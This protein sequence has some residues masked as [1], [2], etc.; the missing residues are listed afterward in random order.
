MNQLIVVLTFI[1]LWLMGCSNYRQ[2]VLEPSDILQDEGILMESPELEPS[3]TNSNERSEEGIFILTMDK[4]L[5]YLDPSLSQYK[6][7]DQVAY[8]DYDVQTHSI[9][10]QK[11]DGRWVVWFLDKMKPELVPNAA[12][13]K[14]LGKAREIVYS[15]V[16]NEGLY[17]LKEGESSQLFT[18]AVKL[19]DTTL[20]GQLIIVQ[21]QDD[22]LRVIDDNG[23]VVY[24]REAVVAY[25]IDKESQAMMVWSENQG[26]ILKLY[27]DSVT[28]YKIINDLTDWLMFPTYSGNF[29]TMAQLSD[30]NLE[31]GIGTLNVNSTLSDERYEISDVLNYDIMRD[32]SYIFYLTDKRE[33]YGLDVESGDITFLGAAVGQMNLERDLN[34]VTYKSNDVLYLID[35]NHQVQVIAEDVYQYEYNGKY[36]AYT[37]SINDLYLESH[38]IVF[39][40]DEA[41]N[42][43][44]LGTHGV[45]YHKQGQIIYKPFDGTKEVIVDSN[46][47]YKNVFFA[48]HQMYQ[49]DTDLNSIF[50]Y[51]VV[52]VE[53]QMILY[54]FD[55]A[56]KIEMIQQIND[57]W[58]YLTGQYEVMHTGETMISLY[59]KY[60]NESERYLSLSLLD[61]NT[62]QIADND[63]IYEAISISEQEAMTMIQGSNQSLDE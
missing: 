28:T 45:Y 1:S 13:M 22:T 49:K 23:K 35:E 48:N 46:D 14:L 18:G 42:Q 21:D 50:G 43:F 29:E 36:F 8:F 52:E 62:L 57:Q 20:N 55:E 19:F 15:G 5:F 2:E 37:N 30:L 12:D 32:G 59:T 51:W 11:K 9:K 4:D 33:L 16:D 60:I 7:S 40:V 39:K 61:S 3:I 53:N 17:L 63:Q 41:V 38:G 31:T 26:V 54:F 58:S 25:R 6:L 34:C 56:G 24:E 10:V 44:A 27:E 47:N